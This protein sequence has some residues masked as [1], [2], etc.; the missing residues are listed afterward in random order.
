[1]LSEYVLEPA[2]PVVEVIYVVEV[3]T[4]AA[5]DVATEPTMGHQSDTVAVFSM[6]EAPEDSKAQGI[7]D[8]MVVLVA[9]CACTKDCKPKRAPKRDGA[10]HRCWRPW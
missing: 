3:A 6:L 1:M 9:S 4:P 10:V 8:T 2:G 5:L 7:I